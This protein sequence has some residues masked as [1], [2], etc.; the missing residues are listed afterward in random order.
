MQ[1]ICHT[2]L[3]RNM[4]GH[5]DPWQY[6]LD[7]SWT[8]VEKY[9]VMPCSQDSKHLSVDTPRLDEKLSSSARQKEPVHQLHAIK[10]VVQGAE[11][12]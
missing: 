10:P 1:A 8:F 3:F 2:S 5:P 7:S 9:N 4:D 6:E 12:L 11:R